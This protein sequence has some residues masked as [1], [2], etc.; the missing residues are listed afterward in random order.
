MKKRVIFLC[1]LLAASAVQAQTNLFRR[2]AVTASSDDLRYTPDN[3]IDGRYDKKSTWLSSPTARPPHT[4]EVSLPRYC[5][6]DSIVLWSGIPEAEMTARERTQAAGF[7]S[8]KNF[9]LQYWDDAN[10]TD[11]PGTTVTENRL[12]RASFRFASPVTSYRFRLYSTDGEAIRVVEFEGYGHEN[13]L[14]AAPAEI[15]RTAIDYPARPE[16]I[17]AS[18]GTEPVGRT[19]R[20]V[21]YNQGY[22]FPEGNASGWME[23]A[24][25]NSARVWATLEYYVPREWV[26]PGQG[27]ATLA[28]FEVRKNALRANP[29]KSAIRWDSIAVMGA[30]RFHST[31]SMVLDYALE[32]L[33]RLGVDV[34]LQTSTRLQERDWAAKWELWQ[35]YYAL[36]FY[37]ARVGDVGMY[38]MMNEPNHRHAGPVPLD[39]WIEMMKVASDAVHCGVE[40]VNKLYNK[41]IT[42]RF[43]GPVT[44]GT[45]TDWW[46]RIA[47]SEGTDYA[48]RPTDRDLVDVFSTHS[49]NLPALGYAGKVESIDK[50]L[51]TNHPQGKTKPIVFT[52]IGRWMNAYLIDKEET[53]DS[54]SL[55]TEWAGIYANAMRG[56]GYGMWAFKFAN[57]RSDTYP[58]GI[59]SGHHHTWKGARWAEDAYENLA[60]G[61]T[62]KASGCDA[63][64]SPAAVTDG[65]KGNNSS[66]AQTSDGEKWVEIDLGRATA[67]G[68]IAI[69]TG[70]A[71]GE[72]T[73][74]D[75]IHALKVETWDGTRWVG[76]KTRE[77]A[78][79]YAQLYY[80]FPEGT[81][82]SRVRLSTADKGR[83][84]IREVKLFGPGTLSAAVESYDV[85][86]VQR[87]AEVVRLFAKGFKGARPLLGSEMSITDSDLDLCASIDSASMTAYVW[88][89]QRNLV[90][91]KMEL[92]LSALGV[93]QGSKIVYEEVSARRYG[94][95]TPLTAGAGGKATFTLPRQSVVLLTV[96]LT[97]DKVR[98]VKADRT[99]VVR[100]GDM[101]GKK[102]GGKELGISLDSRTGSGNRVTY[103]HFTLPDASKAR[104]VLV[105][106]HG[107]CPGEVPFRFHVYGT[108]AGDWKERTLTWASAPALAPGEALVQGVGKGVFVAGEL[109]MTSEAGYHWLD[110]TD[111]VRRHAPRGGTFIL[112]R[113]VREPGDD[114]DKGR[115][116][117][118]SGR[119]S[120]N[121]PVI[122]IW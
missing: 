22:F 35:R 88:L 77:T 105:G 39:L 109:T 59:K 80:T 97:A 40:D 11:I 72:F 67:L 32:E 26:A 120:E 61:C 65:D 33:R 118:V 70:S 106:V 108:A 19:M 85:S 43:V 56:G 42:P 115:T 90:D 27:V 25:A 41:N 3:A 14:L 94:E 103:L 93:K 21:G 122:E 29:E 102:L 45:N 68:G 101:A 81:N 48:G 87:T 46:S 58:R 23:Y 57:T 73:A 111:A 31:N 18:V 44:A 47:A 95:A 64:Y 86:G 51:R 75:R 13:T 20:Y 8:V 53:M 12:Y 30:S 55:F 107:S 112:V 78:I 34:V 79:R 76:L 66:W 100:G 6:I 54:P 74:P 121:P 63:G 96:P 5:D 2:G 91:D 15:D 36:A 10:W 38:A 99:A 9:V 113:E 69:Y 116:A 89:V 17:R 71:G 16:L 114:Y 28:D 117:S 104:R 83:A 98:T 49:Y 37:C 82:A 52:E 84:A 1:L 92:D 119:G 110:V 60:L 50:I 7:W 62:V 4:L 24:G